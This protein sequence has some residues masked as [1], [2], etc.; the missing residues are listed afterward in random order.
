V[1]LGDVGFL[2]GRA[3]REQQLH[4]QDGLKSATRLRVGRRR[5]RSGSW[6]IGTKTSC[7]PWR[8]YFATLRVRPRKRYDAKDDGR[9]CRAAN[10]PGQVC[11]PLGWTQVSPMDT[12]A[13]VFRNGTARVTADYDARPGARSDD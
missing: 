7:G 4:H 11:R 2:L 6:P 13:L 10:P 8:S 1:F 9:R 3:V 5:A 12:D